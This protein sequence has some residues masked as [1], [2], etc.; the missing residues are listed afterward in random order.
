MASEKTIYDFVFVGMGASNSLILSSLIKN[1]LTTDKKIAV[2]EFTRIMGYTAI[3]SSSTKTCNA[4]R[5]ELTCEKGEW[6]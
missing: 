6:I 5:K 4:L 1:G 2:L 3:T